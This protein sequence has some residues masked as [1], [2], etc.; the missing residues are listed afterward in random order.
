MVLPMAPNGW[1]PPPLH[2]ADPPDPST[3]PFTSYG[4]THPPSRPT[5][6]TWPIGSYASPP[7]SDG[8]VNFIVN[9][10]V[11][12]SQIPTSLVS[13]F[14]IQISDPTIAMPTTLNCWYVFSTAPVA[15]SICSMFAG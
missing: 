2:A 5:Q 4:S 15:G 11:A 6:S 7:A 9:T 3:L 13:Q 1:N 14:A 12:G 10:S 8:V